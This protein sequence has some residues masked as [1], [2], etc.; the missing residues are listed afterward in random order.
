MPEML[1]H[2]NDYKR[3]SS[4]N[5]CNREKNVQQINHWNVI[6]VIFHVSSFLSLSTQSLKSSAEREAPLHRARGSSRQ[7]ANVL[8]SWLSLPPLQQ[9]HRAEE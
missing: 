2:F 6:R 8:A 5:S 1:E 4:H 7:M 9:G 3:R